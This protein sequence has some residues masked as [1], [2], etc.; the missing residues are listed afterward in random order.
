MERLRRV[1]ILRRIFK[2]HQ[3][4]SVSDPKPEPDVPKDEEGL[5]AP[6]GTYDRCLS[7]IG[8]NERGIAKIGELFR[9][10]RSLLLSSV[11]DEHKI[12]ILIHTVKEGRAHRP[13]TAWDIWLTDSDRVMNFEMKHSETGLKPS[14]QEN[15]NEAFMEIDKT[16]ELGTL[17]RWTRQ[18]AE[19]GT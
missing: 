11:V 6:S 4:P 10:K 15:L 2:A 7:L 9:T 14:S 19:N 17:N 16:I 8:E 5:L 18:E 12:I 3:D 1:P 13:Y